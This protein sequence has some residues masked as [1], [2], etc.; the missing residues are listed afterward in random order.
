MFRIFAVANMKKSSC[1][2]LYNALIIYNMKQTILLGFSILTMFVFQSVHVSA[3]VFSAVTPSGHTMEFTINGSTVQVSRISGSGKNVIIPENVEYEGV[4]YTVTSLASGLFGF[5]RSITTIELPNSIVDLGESTFANC[6]NLRSINIPNGVTEIGA[7]LFFCC[8]TLVSIV[9]PASVTSI[10][11]H[12]FYDCSSLTEVNI[13]DSVTSIGMG[14][15][16]SCF[17]LTSVVIPNSVR[18]IEKYSFSSCYKLASVSLPDSLISI[19][20][21]AFDQCCSLRQIIIPNTVEWIGEYAFHDCYKLRPV[22]IPNTVDSIGGS[23]FSGVKNIQYSGSASGRPWNANS[24]NGI[25]SGDFVFSDDGGR[26]YAYVG[27]DSE[28]VIPDTVYQIGRWAFS[29]LDNLKSVTIPSSVADIRQYAFFQCRNIENVIIPDSVIQIGNFA[30]YEVRRIVY[31]G[32]APGAPWGAFHMNGIEDGDFVYDDS[33]HT[34]LKTYIGHDSVVVIP[35]T[36]TNIGNGAFAWCDDVVS[37]SIPS[38]VERIGDSAFL[39]CTE[40][41]SVNLPN[42]VNYLGKRAFWSCDHLTSIVIPGSIR[43]IEDGVFSGSG[44]ESVTFEDSLTRIGEYAFWY[45]NLHGELTIPEGVTSIGRGAF[46]HCSGLTAVKFPRTLTSIGEDAFTECGI[47][48]GRIVLYDSVTS[49]GKKAFYGNHFNAV[50]CMNPIPPAIE[51]QAGSVG[52]I[53]VPCGSEQ[54]YQNDSIW[55]TYGS[56]A[57]TSVI[58]DIRSN[59]ESLGTVNITSVDCDG[60]VTVTARAKDGCKLYGWSDG[61]TGNNRT[62]N[63]S[64]DTTILAIFD[65]IRYSIVGKPNNRLYGTV[66][67]SDTVYYGHTVTLTA[68]PNPGYYFTRWN[69]GVTDS[70]RTIIATQNRTYTATFNPIRYTVTVQSSDSLRGTVTGGGEVN[71]NANRTIRAIPATGYHFTHW[72]DGDSNA[73]RHIRV[74]QDTSFIAYFEI[75]RYQLTVLA[76]DSTLGSVSGS[77]VYTHGTRVTATA[78]ANTG[79]RFDRWDDGSILAS[80]S[81]DMTDDTLL[82]AIFLPADTTF[83]HDTTYI[84]VYDTV[85]INVFVHDT[86][87]IDVPVHDTIYINVPVHDTTYIDVPYPVHD[88]TII[89]ETLT[90]TDTLWLH[91]TITIHD[92]IYLP[93]EGIDGADVLNAKIYSSQGQIVVEGADGNAV[94]LYDINGRI[95]ATKRDYGIAIRFDA[96]ASGTYMIKIGNHAARKVVVIR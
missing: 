46:G 69:D 51:Y 33:A 70:V 6:F 24:I 45:T 13:P 43:V 72:S 55:S 65:S 61:A 12:A 19:G 92:T 85:R 4:T 37:V 41:S 17:K 77:G 64:G 52:T 42:S 90:V 2:I 89:I 54:L 75:N 63:V 27:E 60:T 23:A 39:Y 8:T 94:T 96:P 9:L 58:F 29:Y 84:N 28:V 50:F 47:S 86:T 87:Y 53:Y 48:G 20:E 32:T 73:V 35:G 83:V 59:D 16:S 81:F 76:N 95:L 67:G 44:L 34:I 56:I 21:R 18:T 7:N 1:R 88:T 36:V 30:F 66:T 5:A 57:A 78:R 62:I 26:L 91:D 31:H 14:A 68:I 25:I 10:G 82:I 40:L 71:Y 3:Q 49:I 22:S 15:F 38:G 79:N 80:Y 93:Q 74:T 11:E